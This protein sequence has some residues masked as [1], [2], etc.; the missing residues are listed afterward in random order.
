MP[1]NVRVLSINRGLRVFDWGAGT[2]PVRGMQAADAAMVGRAWHGRAAKPDLTIDDPEFRRHLRAFLETPG[3]KGTSVGRDLQ[4]FLKRSFFS[5]VPSKLR[6]AWQRIRS[7][8]SENMVEILEETEDW[9]PFQ[10]HVLYC[11]AVKNV[12]AS[13]KVVSGGSDQGNCQLELL[14]VG[15][16]FEG[17][18]T[19]EV[20][21][22]FPTSE[23]MAVY[24]SFKAVWQ[25]CRIVQPPHEE[26]VFP[27]LWEVRKKA[28]RMTPRRMSTPTKPD[29]NWGKVEETKEIDLSGW[30]KGATHSLEVG[31]GLKWEGSAKVRVFDFEAGPKFVGIRNWK[32][33]CEFKLPG[34]HNYVARRFANVP[35]WWWTVR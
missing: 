22:Q 13:L 32:T 12:Q 8:F 34:S 29:R 9:L 35:W 21:D 20:A 33:V 11:P 24:Y 23:S 30:P 6:S 5:W 4:P 3:I 7:L 14:G 28:Q 18:M 31:A 19:F 15:G 16:G 10:I 25:K 1:E 27:R 17:S 2:P 26:I